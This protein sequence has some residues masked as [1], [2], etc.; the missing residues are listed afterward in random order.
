LHEPALDCGI[1]RHL[2]H[3]VDERDETIALYKL[4]Y[5]AAV[6]EQGYLDHSPHLWISNGG[7]P[8]WWIVRKNRVSKNKRQIWL[9]NV[10]LVVLR[11]RIYPP[12]AS[13]TLLSLESSS[14]LALSEDEPFSSE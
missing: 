14:F 13:K 6:V 9:V 7:C 4:A 8:R 10:S 5:E 12:T 1:S 11:K 2:G 3:D